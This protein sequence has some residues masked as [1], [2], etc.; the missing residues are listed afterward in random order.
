MSPLI[1]DISNIAIS[2]MPEGWA[3]YKWEC[4]P[5]GY[6][7]TGSVPAGQ[8][9]KGP[10]KGQPKHLGKGQVVVIGEGDLRE[11]KA[12]YLAS[13]GNCWDCKATG[14]VWAGW[15]QTHGVSHRQCSSCGGAGKVSQ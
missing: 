8:Y 7:V 2:K 3:P 13:T 4:V 9:R 14:Q 11:A 10:R 12:L 6:L 15:T 5:G 1:D